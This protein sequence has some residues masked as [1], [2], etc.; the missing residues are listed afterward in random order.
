MASPLIFGQ[1]YRD[2]RKLRGWTQKHLA[3]E[4]IVTPAESN[5]PSS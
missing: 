4:S 5:R 3:R 2:A 1:R